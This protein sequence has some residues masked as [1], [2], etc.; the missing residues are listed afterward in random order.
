MKFAVLYGN[1]FGERIICNL[2]FPLAC[3]RFGAC[4]VDFC[5]LCKKYDNSKD[6]VFAAKLPD[7]NSNE[8]L[9]DVKQYLDEFSCDVVLA[10]NVHPDILLDLH[11]IAEFKALIAPA[12]NH[13]WILPG[14]RN[15]LF[16]RYKELGIE[17]YSPK[18]FCSLKGDGVIGKFCE[19]LKIGM[20]EFRVKMED[21][22]ILNV[23]II[24][25]DPCGCSYYVAKKMKGYFI[26]DLSEFYKTIHQHQCAYPCMA[27]MDR[28]PE[29]GEAPFHLAGYITVY[30]FAE[31]CGVDAKHFVPQKFWKYIL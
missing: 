1:E 25:S 16:E 4:G 8:Q 13:R 20:P 6:L 14:L 31:A 9:E 29:L 26:D 10:I 28:D 22:V 24:S 2:A 15:Q 7:A 11:K 12:E 27:S 3:P 21:N 30:K 18:P 17:F 23:E 5:D 19:K